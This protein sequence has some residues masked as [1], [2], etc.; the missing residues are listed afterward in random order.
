[1]YVLKSTNHSVL[2]VKSIRWI[3]RQIYTVL[4]KMM[5]RRTKDE[6]DATR[7]KIVDAA[8]R[9]FL[10]QGVSSTTLEGIAAEAGFTRG[11]VYHHFANKH[12]LLIELWNMVKPPTEGISEELEA[13]SHRGGDPLGTMEK[14]IGNALKQVLSDPRTSAIHTV[15]MHNCEFVEKINPMVVGEM[16]HLVSARDLIAKGIGMAKDAGQI[17]P[18]LDLQELASALMC[19]C[20]GLLA[21]VLRNRIMSDQTISC[22]IDQALSVFFS[23]IRAPKLLP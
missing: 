21:M 22:D 23:G 2:V 11:A 13:A 16:R 12:A 19:Y 17:R 7:E 3:F 18:E 4:T 20:Y 10:R 5:A 8:I 6:A 1:M 14:R 9:L 15:F